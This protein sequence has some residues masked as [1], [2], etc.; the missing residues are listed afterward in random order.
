MTASAKSAKF[1]LKLTKADR[2]F[3]SKHAQEGYLSFQLSKNTSSDCDHC[4]NKLLR[5][6]YETFFP[7]GKMHVPVL[8]KRSEEGR[9]MQVKVMEEK[10]TTN[11]KHEDVFLNTR[12]VPNMLCLIKKMF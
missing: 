12:Y 3:L 5:S 7:V 8:L 2:V 10:V 9:I 6:N 11:M 1:E 4:E